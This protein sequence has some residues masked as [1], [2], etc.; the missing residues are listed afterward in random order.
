M[1]TAA[2]VVVVVVVDEKSRVDARQQITDLI[3]KVEYLASVTPPTRDKIKKGVD[4]WEHKIYVRNFRDAKQY[5]TEIRAKKEAL[6]K[7]YEQLLDGKG[8]NGKDDGD[9][10]ELVK[11]IIKRTEMLRSK[12]RALTPYGVCESQKSEYMKIFEICAAITK[13][14]SKEQKAERQE[15]IAIILPL[16]RRLESNVE[17]NVESIRK[18]LKLDTIDELLELEKTPLAI[19][20]QHWRTVGPSDA[21]LDRLKGLGAAI[22]GVHALKQIV[23]SYNKV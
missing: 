14:K 1:A 11:I 3:V 5:A 15:K 18:K 2:A 12:L 9:D 19:M 21:Q 17:P 7:R 22:G 10:G 4:E 23:A 6:R 20:E 13:L 8:R 16:L